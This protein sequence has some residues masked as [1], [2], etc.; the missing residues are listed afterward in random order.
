MF[1]TLYDR[2]LL[3]YGIAFRI[4]KRVSIYFDEK[5]PIFLQLAYIFGGNTAAA[6]AVCLRYKSLIQGRWSA[7][8]SGSNGFS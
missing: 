1:S 4:S 6:V 5:L 7:S 2:E 8:C 3:R